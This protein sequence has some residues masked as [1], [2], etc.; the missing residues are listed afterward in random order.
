MRC[1]C[2]RKRYVVFWLNKIKQLE[3]SVDDKIS[4][5]LSANNLQSNIF[6]FSELY[7]R[8]HW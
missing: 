5:I 3:L 1:T 2:K 8:S 6:S 7:L 4:L